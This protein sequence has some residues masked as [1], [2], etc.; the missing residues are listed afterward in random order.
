MI[1]MAMSHRPAP[2]G[3]KKGELQE[4]F[5]KTPLKFV[6][7]SPNAG[8]WHY[9][10][11]IKEVT[12]MR[13]EEW[14]P[15]EGYSKYE[16]SNH[17]QVRSVR[18]LQQY[19]TEKGYRKI[20][21][22]D[23]HGVSRKK[24]V[25]HLVVDAF[26]KDVP[27]DHDVHHID[28]DRDNNSLGNLACISME[29]HRKIHGR[30]GINPEEAE[31][32]VVLRKSGMSRSQIS[33]ETNIPLSAVRTALQRVEVGKVTKSRCPA[34]Q[35]C[36]NRYQRSSERYLTKDEVR[37]IKRLLAE[38]HAN[39]CVARQLGVDPKTVRDIAHGRA[40]RDDSPNVVA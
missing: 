34:P 25:H 21:L 33:A 23:D 22:V 15:I 17:G 12:N 13:N 26:M 35:G 11:P 8:I 31:A 2:R 1:L 28:G 16:V 36:D 7:S 29:D 3:H 5:F 20:E 32:L 19:K 40:H 10:T 18:V 9:G 4:N 24:A 39:K 30:P 14:R 37:L 6:A 27:S 38:G